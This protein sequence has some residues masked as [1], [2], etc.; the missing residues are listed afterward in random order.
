MRL[1]DYRENEEIV[2]SV[3]YNNGRIGE[4][5]NNAKGRRGTTKVS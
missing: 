2:K 1:C 5:L 3:E 4:Y